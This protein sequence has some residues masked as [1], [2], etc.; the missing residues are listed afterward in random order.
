[1]QHFDLHI[2]SIVSGL[3]LTTVAIQH[4]DLDIRTQLVNPE[5]LIGHMTLFGYS[6]W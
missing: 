6:P 2:V 5:R 4:Y 1:M 3:S